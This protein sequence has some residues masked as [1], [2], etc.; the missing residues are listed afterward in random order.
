M[1]IHIC[2]VMSVMEIKAYAGM[3]VLKEWGEQTLALVVV[4]S[5]L[6]H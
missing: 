1:I 3:A 6:L 2:C 4:S 5:V